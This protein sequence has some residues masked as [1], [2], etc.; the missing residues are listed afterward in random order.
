MQALF[1]EL[2]FF[3]PSQI[4][5]TGKT[6]FKC[7]LKIRGGYYGN[8]L[9]ALGVFHSSPQPPN[10]YSCQREGIVLSM[11]CSLGSNTRAS[12]C[13][14]EAVDLL[15][16]STTG[17]M[18]WDFL[19]D[20]SVCVVHAHIVYMQTQVPHSAVL[21]VTSACCERQ[22]ERWYIIKALSLSS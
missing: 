11:S 7:L 20:L 21:R 4:D 12:L 3:S 17:R 22:A 1:S 19:T 14:S 6:P 5:E 9:F 13:D 8:V 10:L 18:K 15:L 2:A 16:S